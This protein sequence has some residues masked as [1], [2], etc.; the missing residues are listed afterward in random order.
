ML[1]TLQSDG[2]LYESTMSQLEGAIAQLAPKI[3]TDAITKT[4]AGAKALGWIHAGSYYMTL[5][6]LASSVV[7]ASGDYDL[8][9]NH[10]YN[11][12][13]SKVSVRIRTVMMAYKEA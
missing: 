1:S 5:G 13:R 12:C 9:A 4:V 8:T 10:T 6:N 2:G 7:E 3:S 11:R